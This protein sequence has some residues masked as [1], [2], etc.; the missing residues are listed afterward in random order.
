MKILVVNTGQIGDNLLLTPIFRAL[1]K[2]HPEAHIAHLT[3]STTAPILAGNPDLDE[4]ISLDKKMGI[5][6]YVSFLMNLRR[7]NYDIVL[8]YLGNP[9]TALISLITGAPH[10]LGYDYRIRKYC[11]TQV[12]KRNREPVYAVDFKMDLVKPLQI[13]SQGMELTLVIPSEAW[14][15]PREFIEG[16]PHEGPLIVFSPVSRRQYKRW[17]LERYSR[18]ADSLVEKY[19]ARIVLIWGP[20]EEEI[21]G[22]FT[23]NMKNQCFVAPRT[24][25]MEMAGIIAL[26]DLF[27]GNDNGPKHMAVAVGTPTVTIFGPTDP[28]AWTP[29][30][31]PQHVAVKKDPGCIKCVPRRCRDLKCLD[32]VSVDD[33]LKEVEKHQVGKAERHHHDQ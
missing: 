3:S 15:R 18:L 33:V 8:D 14:K 25:I 30:N 17:P 7:R 28:R 11:Y 19:K 26:S 21:V 20:G 22:T 31:N 24:T 6:R 29:P 5:R 9:R 2:A 32:M 10:R 4:L 12:V 27:I 13:K 1:R 23:A 16:L